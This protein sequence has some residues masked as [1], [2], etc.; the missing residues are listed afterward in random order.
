MVYFT[1]DPLPEE[2]EEQYWSHIQNLTKLHTLRLIK[3]T[4][5]PRF[6]NLS[7]Q[8]KVWFFGK[9]KF[10]EIFSASAYLAEESQLHGTM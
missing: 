4:V 9:V 10:C 8:N 2:V 6:V 7:S 1:L 5:F 3:R